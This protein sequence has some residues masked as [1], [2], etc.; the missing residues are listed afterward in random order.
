MEETSPDTLNTLRQKIQTTRQ[1]LIAKFSLS[2]V[3]DHRFA[4]GF[5]GDHTVVALWPVTDGGIPEDARFYAS[6]PSGKIE[7]TIN[8][9]SARTFFKPGKSYY[10][11]FVE[12][13]E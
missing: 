8:N 5:S 10:V 9:Q 7:L 6:T 4:P 11:M 12:A 3:V 2:T 1:A 13:P